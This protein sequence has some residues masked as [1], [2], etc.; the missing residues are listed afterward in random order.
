MRQLNDQLPR[1]GQLSFFDKFAARSD[2]ALDRVPLAA[3]GDPISSRIAA[4]E[5]TSSGRW[6]SQRREQGHAFTSMEIAHAA[7]LDRYLVAGRLPDLERD[8]LVSAAP[9]A[10]AGRADGSRSRGGFN[11]DR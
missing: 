2:G 3:A 6:A 9:C 10:R 11:E 8:G 1:V 5:V 7:G 4:A